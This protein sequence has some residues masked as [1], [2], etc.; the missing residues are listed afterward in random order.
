[1]RRLAA[2]GVDMDD[3]GLTLEN[4]GIAGFHESSQQVLA[5]LAAKAHQLSRH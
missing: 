1:M 5:A 2:V 3:V 4:Q